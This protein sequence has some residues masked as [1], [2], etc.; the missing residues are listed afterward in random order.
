MKALQRP[1]LW[2]GALCL[3]RH[4]RVC[5]A[6][7]SEYPL[8]LPWRRT[9]CKCGTDTRALTPRQITISLALS[10]IV[11]VVVEIIEWI[12]QRMDRRSA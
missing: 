8:D 7:S 5:P 9:I 11:F 10:S 2:P 3:D 1:R 4:T 6:D 12:R